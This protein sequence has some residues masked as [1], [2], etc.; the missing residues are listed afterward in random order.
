MFLV[1]RETRP[2]DI[3]GMHGA[4]AVLTDIAAASPAQRR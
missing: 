4:Q 2:E 1:R 3:R